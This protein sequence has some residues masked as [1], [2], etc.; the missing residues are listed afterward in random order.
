M[1]TNSFN[2]K[3]FNIVSQQSIS[4]CQLETHVAIQCVNDDECS[5]V[6]SEVRMS[7]SLM[8]MNL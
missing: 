2:L 1:H 7:S 5:K 4:L 3:E 8:I 6:T